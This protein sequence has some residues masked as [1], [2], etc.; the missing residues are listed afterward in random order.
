[1][2]AWWASMRPRRST[3]NLT[4]N[5][6]YFWGMCLWND[7]PLPATLI[8]PTSVSLAKEMK[9]GLSCINKAAYMQASI[10]VSNKAFSEN[11]LKLE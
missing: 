1:M 7:Y 5:V 9:T 2:V 4:A 6:Y 3:T 10:I 11:S 8:I